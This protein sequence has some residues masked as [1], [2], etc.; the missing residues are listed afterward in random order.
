MS[1]RDSVEPDK[2][3]FWSTILYRLEKEVCISPRPRQELGG[4]LN[5]IDS[6]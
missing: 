3:L 4:D 1:R 5:T 2:S 6:Q